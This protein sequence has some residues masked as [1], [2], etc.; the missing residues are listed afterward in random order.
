MNKSLTDSDQIGYVAEEYFESHFSRNENI[1]SKK[2][3]VDK[4]TD[5][6]I[7]E[8][9]ANVTK[10]KSKTDNI[11]AVNVKGCDLDK[12]SAKLSISDLKMA[13]GA[14][15]PMLYFVR[16]LK[17]KKSY[18]SFL[19]AVLFKKMSEHIREGH[20]NFYLT[21][22]RLT[23]DKGGFRYALQHFLAPKVQDKVR[24]LRSNWK[25]EKI[26]GVSTHIDLNLN[27]VNSKVNVRVQKIEGIIAADSAIQSSFRDLMLVKQWSHCILPEEFIKPDLLGHLNSL[28]DEIS[29]EAL[30]HEETSVVSIV[31]EGR[32]QSC[33]FQVKSFG[34]ELAF[35]HSTGLSL[36]FS[37]RRQASADQAGN[38]S[39][40]I[41]FL[42]I[43]DSHKS[44]TDKSPE[45]RSSN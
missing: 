42:E 33:E 22:S 29:F 7:C 37:K 45:A 31:S 12:T 19:D 32:R 39:L 38:I 3:P 25:V 44:Y 27:H 36:I 10:L 23:E 5:F 16:N 26:V 41:C 15:Y 8:I 21:E 9:F 6:Y 35:T 34:D 30:A 17:T 40:K 14:E 4:G 2:H 18:Y 28:A 13:L 43:N 11:I 1:T 20:E 24:I